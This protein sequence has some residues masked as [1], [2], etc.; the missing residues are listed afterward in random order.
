MT[1]TLIW[2]Y[3]KIFLVLTIFALPLESQSSENQFERKFREVEKRWE[4][5]YGSSHPFA[6]FERVALNEKVKSVDLKAMNCD[7]S[8]LGSKYNCDN[9]VV[10]IGDKIHSLNHCFPMPFD[11][12]AL[13]NRQGIPGGY[14]DEFTQFMAKTWSRNASVVKYR[15]SGAKMCVSGKF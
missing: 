7:K 9:G 14:W 4:A 10:V 15:A 3:P 5:Q 8:F 12:K 2:N 11:G 13:L 6:I 1:K